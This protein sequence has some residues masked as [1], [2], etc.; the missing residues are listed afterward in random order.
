MH[1][2]LRIIALV[3]AVYGV[4]CNAAVYD[5]RDFGAKGDGQHIDSDAINEAM[6]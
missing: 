4:A 5:V 2:K 3:L 6:V 1:Y